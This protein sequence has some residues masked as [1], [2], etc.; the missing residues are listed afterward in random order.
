MTLLFIHG[1][2]FTGDVFAQQLPAF[3]GSIAPNL[4]GHAASGS[5][6]TVAEFGDFIEQF[7]KEH[8]LHE[9]TL[10]GNSL[11]GA[12]ALD[13]ALRKNRQVRS[14][15]LLGSGARL[16]VAPQILEG[17]RTDFERTSQELAQM[18]YANPTAQQVAYAISAMHHVGPS[19]TLADYE[20]CNEFDVT[21]R[22]GELA[23]PLLA[24]TGEHDRM[25]PP[26]YAQFLADR[27]QNGRVRIIPGAGHLVMAE[28]PAETNA[29]IAEFL[30]LGPARS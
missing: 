1:S 22:L 13:V 24:L 9:V 6:A 8:E 23:L 20:A 11:G 25:T 30:T 7:I 29:A 15:V 4:S 27:V 5:A 14:I 16:R 26:K 12:V 28:R 19:Q 10:C 18:L 21:D 3:S 2:G 17:L